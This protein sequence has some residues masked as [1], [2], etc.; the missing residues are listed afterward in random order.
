[1]GE[2]YHGPVVSSSVKHDWHAAVGV[3]SNSDGVVSRLAAVHAP[4]SSHLHSGHTAAAPSL[5][6]L[7]ALGTYCTFRQG[8]RHWG[9]VQTAVDEVAE[10]ATLALQK[11]QDGGL[12]QVCR[13]LAWKTARIW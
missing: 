8:C 3:A 4:A 12:L 2:R 6:P 13:G 1:M 10:E 11:D 7:H 5:L 9:A